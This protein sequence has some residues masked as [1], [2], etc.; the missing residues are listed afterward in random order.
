MPGWRLDWEGKRRYDGK[1]MI[2]VN[3]KTYQKGT[4]EKALQLVRV[5]QEVAQETGV[6]IIPVV[7][8]VD[9]C[10]FS[11]QGFEVWVQHVDDVA[12]GAHTGQILPEAVMAAGAKG[13]LLNH[14]ENKL[15]ASLVRSTLT[16]CQRLSLR[17]L[18]CASSVEEGK[19]LAQ[20]KPNFIAYEPPELIGSR[21][22]SVATAK[23][24]VIDDFAEEV[25]KIP[26]IVGAG[27]HS[28]QDVQ[29][30]LD[31]GAVGILVATDVVLAKK[32]K[33]E[34]LDL[35]EGFK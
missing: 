17:T 10:R 13:T 9:L 27:I 20:F 32:P 33:K 19:E 12:Y 18:V 31:L 23:P 30:A 2:F 22:A 24:E 35:T 21:Q 7:Q 8:V 14:S 6:T 11:C 16:Q 26:L 3:F 34:L 5:C 1:R 25:K 4:G 28:R 29:T 15:P